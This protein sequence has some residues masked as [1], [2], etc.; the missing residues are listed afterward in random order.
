MDNWYC[1]RDI[2]IG[3]AW[4]QGGGTGRQP[5]WLRRRRHTKRLIPAC[6][7]VTKRL[8]KRIQVSFLYPLSTPDL[9]REQNTKRPPHR[10][11]SRTVYNVTVRP[12]TSRH[13]HRSVWVQHGVNQAES[14]SNNAHKGPDSLIQGEGGSVTA[15]ICFWRITGLSRDFFSINC[16]ILVEFCVFL[17]LLEITLFNCSNI[18]IH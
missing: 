9:H 15:L 3:H 6:L 8:K 12:H 11:G 1:V 10:T 13:V 7:N 4:Y 18:S 5:T 16:F 17:L 14:M 2:N